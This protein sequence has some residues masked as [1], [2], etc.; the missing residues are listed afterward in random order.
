MRAVASDRRYQPIMTSDTHTPK[1][2]SAW[3][4]AP[5]TGPTGGP[6]YQATGVGV[7]RSMQWTDLP[8]PPSGTCV[9]SCWFRSSGNLA[10]NSGSDVMFFPYLYV[11]SVYRLPAAPPTRSQ[12]QATTWRRWTGALTVPPGGTTGRVVVSMRPALT[13]GTIYMSGLRADIL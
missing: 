1:F 13:G 2:L 3:T 12:M 10:S 4:I 8:I 6:V 11:G 7:E 9:M 5:E